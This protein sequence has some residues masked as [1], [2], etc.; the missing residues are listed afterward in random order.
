[1]FV[2]VPEMD[3]DQATVCYTEVIECEFSVNAMWL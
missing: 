2:F 1:M 3:Y